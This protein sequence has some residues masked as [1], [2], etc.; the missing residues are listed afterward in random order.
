[1]IESLFHIFL[2]ILGLGFLVFIHELGHYFVAR[3]EGMK[4]EA[5]SIG[6]GRSIYSWMHQGVRWQIGWL[7]FG[8]FVR[9]AGMQKEGSL[10]P[11]E[12]PGGFFSKK[13]MQRIRVALA[14]PFVNIVFALVVFVGLW[15]SG[16]QDKPFQELTRRI[17]WVD[18]RS[19]LYTQGL[20]PGD[21][22]EA[23]DGRSA[24]ELSGEGL[25]TLAIASLMNDGKAQIHLER[26]DSRT[27]EESPVDMNLSYDP[28]KERIIPASYLG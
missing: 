11:H 27:G 13:P 18:P 26:F 19:T 2:G 4:V 12:I 14:G 3:R 17:G 7:P 22:L 9:I 8:G 15:L 5:F 20:R 16:G 21:F 24:Q 23:V 28:S 6:F 1:M 10:E 25:K